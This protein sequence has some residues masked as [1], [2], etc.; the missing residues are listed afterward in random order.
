MLPNS[1]PCRIKESRKDPLL[2]PQQCLPLLQ[3]CHSSRRKE[4]GAEL[5]LIAFPLGPWVPE[6]SAHF[7]LQA[8]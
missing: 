4:E 5:L 1:P 3:P 8:L 2:T 7:V 6:D